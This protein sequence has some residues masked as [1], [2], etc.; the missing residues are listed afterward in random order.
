MSP[1]LPAG[2]NDDE[3]LSIPVAPPGSAII[4]AVEDIACPEVRVVEVRIDGNE[5]SVKESTDEGRAFLMPRK[6]AVLADRYV[7]RQNDAS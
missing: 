3:K 6:V 7:Y 5:D 2:F 1:H 4:V